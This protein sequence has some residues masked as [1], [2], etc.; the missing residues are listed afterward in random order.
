MPARVRD[1][2][3][4]NVKMRRDVGF[5]PRVTVPASIA[6]ILNWLK[7]DGYMEFG[8][9]RFYNT[10]WMELLKERGQGLTPVSNRRRNSA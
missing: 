10:Q 4:S 1:Y 2:R 6:N 5:T 7:S 3:C 8:N 9:P